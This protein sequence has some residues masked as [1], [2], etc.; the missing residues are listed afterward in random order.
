[1]Y[2]YVINDHYSSFYGIFYDFFFLSGTYRGGGRS[3]HFVFLVSKCNEKV[4]IELIS[5]IGFNSTASFDLI[6]TCLHFAENR[7]RKF[8]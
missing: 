3:N 6:F 1:M 5:R 7:K 4:G 8:R 2:Q